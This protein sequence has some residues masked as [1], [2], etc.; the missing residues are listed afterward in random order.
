MN[1]GALESHKWDE[2]NDIKKL[3]G[4]WIFRDKFEILYFNLA[5]AKDHFTCKQM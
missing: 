5:S 1:V 4:G 3:V 2:Q